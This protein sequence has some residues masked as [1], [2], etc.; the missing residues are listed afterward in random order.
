MFILI[1]I[2]DIMFIGILI[3]FVGLVIC[4]SLGEQWTRE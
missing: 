3:G 1:G 4:Q 2:I